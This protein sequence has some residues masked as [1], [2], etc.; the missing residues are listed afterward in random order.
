MMNVILEARVA[1]SPDVIL[2]E[3]DGEAVLLDL[4][5][6]CY[7]GLD[8]VGTRIWRLIEHDGDLKA[9]HSALLG[10]FD[11][12]PDHLERDMGALIGQL[13]EAGLVSVEATGGRNP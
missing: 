3:I 13:A 12:E 6:E 1:I 5:S 10:E 8:T 11:V 7:F 2:Q 9:V 4:K